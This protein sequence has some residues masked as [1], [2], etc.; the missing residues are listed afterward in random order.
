MNK[1]IYRLGT[2]LIFMACFIAFA[3]CASV[4]TVKIPADFPEIHPGL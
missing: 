1:P 2:V 3:G 4:D